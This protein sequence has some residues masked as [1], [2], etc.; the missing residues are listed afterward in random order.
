LESGVKDKLEGLELHG[1]VSEVREIGSPEEL[2]C[3]VV[4]RPKGPKVRATWQSYETLRV[5]DSWRFHV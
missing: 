4:E 5:Q 1:S 2:A 3:S